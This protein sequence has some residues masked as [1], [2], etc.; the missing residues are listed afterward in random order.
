MQ[1]DYEKL[2]NFIIPAHVS[3][4]SE[5]VETSVGPVTVY[6]FD[7]GNIGLCWH[8]HSRLHEHMM[9]IIE[10]RVDAGWNTGAKVWHITA[11]DAP[12]VLM[13]IRTL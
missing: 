7:E 8:F 9:P 3:D 5:R 2:P 6:H 13:D 1:A 12:G 11:E 4:G 10:G